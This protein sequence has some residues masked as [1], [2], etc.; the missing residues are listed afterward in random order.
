MSH[1]YLKQLNDKNA[2]TACQG[3]WACECT[4]GID[5]AT[6][7]CGRVG[8]RAGRCVSVPAR[9]S[10]VTLARRGIHVGAST[11]GHVGASPCGA[12]RRVGTLARWRVVTWAHQRVGVSTH[13][14]IVSVRGR[15]VASSRGTS[16]RR[17]EWVGAL[18]RGHVGVLARR[19]VAASG[20][21]CGASARQHVSALG[22]P[23]YINYEK[24]GWQISHWQLVCGSYTGGG[25]NKVSCCDSISE[26]TV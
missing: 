10:A 13:W 19:R 4:G 20:G 15:V 11:C 17:R 2:P 9:V 23:N 5:V 26:G 1:V 18:T 8:M 3:R 25:A 24:A 12:C 22:A 6:L 14:R 16:A 21:R 7:V